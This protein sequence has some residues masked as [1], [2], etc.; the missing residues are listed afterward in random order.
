M[1]ARFRSSVEA[2][3]HHLYKLCPLCVHQVLER[4]TKYAGA[5]FYSVMRVSVIRV[6]RGEIQFVNTWKLE[7]WKKNWANCAHD[8]L[9]GYLL[10]LTCF[11]FSCVHFDL[12][13]RHFTVFTNPTLRQSTVDF[14]FANQMDPSQSHDIIESLSAGPTSRR[15]VFKVTHFCMKRGGKCP[16]VDIS[17]FQLPITPKMKND[18]CQRHWNDF[19]FI[20][21]AESRNS[22][23]NNVFQNIQPPTPN[24]VSPPLA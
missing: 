1:L 19:W 7:P 12:G 17:V 20:L 3:S 22:F 14:R 8:L 23:Q 10:L 2:L 15:K 21:S 24:L 13:C 18:T 11:F 4:T 6:R 16:N 5:S 9:R